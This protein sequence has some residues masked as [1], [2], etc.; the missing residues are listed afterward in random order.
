MTEPNKEDEPR[1][2]AVVQDHR[3]EHRS[4]AGCFYVLGQPLVAGLVL[5]A[6]V[7][8]QGHIEVV[9]FVVAQR[10][11]V[12]LELGLGGRHQ[13]QLAADLYQAAFGESLP[14]CPDGL[15]EGTQRWMEARMALAKA[16][17]GLVDTVSQVFSCSAIRTAPSSCNGV[18]S[19]E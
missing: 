12:L 1:L 5:D 15:M 14:A 16:Q 13:A 3:P 6:V 19:R 9:V 7:R 11:L 8:L 4:C 17:P 2:R 18:S 10:R